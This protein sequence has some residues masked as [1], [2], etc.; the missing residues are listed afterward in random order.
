MEIGPTKDFPQGKLNEDD[1][2]G[3]DIAIG[4]ESGNVRIDFGEPTAWI[5]F[6]PDEALAFA[7]LIVEHAMA[8]KWRS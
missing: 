4:S 3:I 1:E 6:P 8:L 2:G 7:N 5:A